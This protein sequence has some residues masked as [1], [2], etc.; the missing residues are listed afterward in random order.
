MTSHTRMHEKLGQAIANGPNGLAEAEIPNTVPHRRSLPT[1]IDMIEI[2]DRLRSVDDAAVA[3][4]AES[5]EQRG[6]IYPIQ[7]TTIEPGRFRLIAGAHRI[8]AARKLCW[9]HIEAFLVDDLA[10]GRNRPPRNRREPVQGRAH[11]CNR[12]RPHFFATRKEI[13]RAPVS[14]NPDTVEIVRAWNR[15]N[16]TLAT[17]AI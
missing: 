15:D 4:I 5:M 3:H 8:A 13:Y 2:A 14:G 1:P 10:G 16:I 12:S 11:P 6:Q 9:T 7:I 17:I